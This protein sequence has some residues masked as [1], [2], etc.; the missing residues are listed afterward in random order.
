MTESI[1]H[2]LTVFFIKM[3]NKHKEKGV[4]SIP[5]FTVPRIILLP[6]YDRLVE[7]GSMLPLDLLP[8]EEKESLVRECREVRNVRYTDESL[9]VAAKILHLIRTINSHS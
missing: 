9:T 2:Q 3:Y 6:L 1:N 8:E 4:T 5:T 7:D